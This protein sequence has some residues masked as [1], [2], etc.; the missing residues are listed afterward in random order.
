MSIHRAV[1]HLTH[2]RYDREIFLGPQIFPLRRDAA[3]PRADLELCAEGV[4]GETLYQLAAR[5]SVQL[6]RAIGFPERRREMRIEVEVMGEMSVIN[7][8]DSSIAGWNAVLAVASTMLCIPADAAIRPC[9]SIAPEAE[10]RRLARFF[11]TGHTPRPSSLPI[12][13]WIPIFLLPSICAEF[14]SEDF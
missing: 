12:G 10:S 2:D 5:S 1:H 9:R 13:R 11:R 7:P 6:S 3:L 14:R 8:F 4:A